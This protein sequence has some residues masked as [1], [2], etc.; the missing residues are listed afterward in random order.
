MCNPGSVGQQHQQ[1]LCLWLDD[2]TSNSAI[3]RAIHIPKANDAYFIFPYISTKFINFPLFPK[4]YKFPPIFIQFT[5]FGLICFC[6]STY[7]DHMH[8]R[9]MYWTPLA[10]GDVQGTI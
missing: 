8:F 10:T 5:F 2:F 1:A 4:I 9:I 6:V 3:G 7:F